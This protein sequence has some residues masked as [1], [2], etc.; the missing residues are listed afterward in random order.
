MKIFSREYKQRTGKSNRKEVVFGFI[1]IGKIIQ[2]IILP[3]R[4]NE[5][6]NRNI[7]RNKNY[8]TKLIDVQTKEY[9]FR[10]VKDK[11]L[12]RYIVKCAHECPRKFLF[13]KIR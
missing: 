5:K 1:F 13:L 7:I 10:I 2:S 3:E 9:L 11:N 8:S 12:K 4:C 6:Y